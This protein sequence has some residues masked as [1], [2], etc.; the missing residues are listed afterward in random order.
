MLLRGNARS[1]MNFKIRKLP[2][3]IVTLN[4]LYGDCS[5]YYIYTI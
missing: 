4:L 3:R 1:H 2:G 5:S